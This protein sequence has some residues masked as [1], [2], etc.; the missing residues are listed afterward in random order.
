MAKFIDFTIELHGKSQLI[1]V[2]VDNIASVIE[3]TDKNENTY[4]SIRTVGAAE[5]NIRL[6][7]Y[8]MGNFR[9]KVEALK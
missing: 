8:N 9:E 5:N 3:A 7:G 1:L 2:N 6:N 4:I